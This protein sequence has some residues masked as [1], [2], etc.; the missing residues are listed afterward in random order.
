MS[1][2]LPSFSWPCSV[3][4]SSTTESTKRFR[5]A[6]LVYVC[7]PDLCAGW[8]AVYIAAIRAYCDQ[9]NVISYSLY[10]SQGL[11]WPHYSVSL[12]LTFR[13]IT[14]F[15]TAISCPG[16]DVLL[17]RITPAHCHGLAACVVG[18]LVSGTLSVLLSWACR[19]IT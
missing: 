11:F 5:Q 12:D 7:K 1:L 2:D 18:V 19:L 17:P 3:V 14:Q 9:S 16:L 8:G 13:D 4:F 6:F 10:F 15:I